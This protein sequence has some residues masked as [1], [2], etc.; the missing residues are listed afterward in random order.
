MTTE[1]VGA[2]TIVGKRCE[3]FDGVILAL[4]S[5]C[6]HP[7]PVAGDNSEPP[8]KRYRAELSLLTP[9]IPRRLTHLTVDPAGNVYFV[10]E[11]D[12]GD[13]VAFIAGPSD[14]PRAT[15]LSSVDILSAAGAAAGDKGNIQS[16]SAGPGGEIY[17]YFLGGGKRNTIACSTSG[18]LRKT[19]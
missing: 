18:V 14:V 9:L 6:D 11:S 19:L 10:Q 13:D 17:F 1:H 8:P 16:I 2:A 5:G 4:A 7:E 3:R 15:K 12:D